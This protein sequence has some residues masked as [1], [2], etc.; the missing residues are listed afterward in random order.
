MITARLIRHG[1]VTPEAIHADDM[2]WFSMN[3]SEEEDI[4]VKWMRRR[5]KD[6]VTRRGVPGSILLQQKQ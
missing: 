5:L 3:M 1:P 2:R 4:F 6:K